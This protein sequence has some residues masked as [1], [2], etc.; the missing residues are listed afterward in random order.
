MDSRSTFRPRPDGAMG[1][2]GEVSQPAIGSA[3][4]KRVGVEA[5]RQIRGLSRGVTASP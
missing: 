1:R 4:A 3:G 5:R 2:R